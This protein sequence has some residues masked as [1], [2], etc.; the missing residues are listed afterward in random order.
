[1]P[2]YLERVPRVIVL[3]AARLRRAVPDARERVDGTSGQ[4]RGDLAA[5]LRVELAKPRDPVWT[6]RLLALVRALDRLDLGGGLM[7]R[8]RTLAPPHD[9]TPRSGDVEADPDAVALR[10]QDHLRRLEAPRAPSA[11]PVR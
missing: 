10:A 11:A 4:L 9:V 6:A 8:G 7:D 1:V 5:I 3:D 2:D